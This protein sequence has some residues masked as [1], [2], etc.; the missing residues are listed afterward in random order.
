MHWLVLVSLATILFV[1]VAYHFD[2]FDYD[3][4]NGQ[5]GNSLGYAFFYFWAL[6]FGFIGW[7]LSIVLLVK[8]RHSRTEHS[9]Y[10]TVYLVF[11][12]IGFYWAYCLMQAS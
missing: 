5:S 11:G 2:S 3:D 1:L 10:A 6:V 8:E 4:G 12:A 7:M 9:K